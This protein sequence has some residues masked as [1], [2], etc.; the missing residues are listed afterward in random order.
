MPL[1]C[2][3]RAHN[4]AGRKLTGPPI[5]E[6]GSQ[7]TSARI[8]LRA[9]IDVLPA[10]LNF[11]VSEQDPESVSSRSGLSQRLGTRQPANHPRYND[12]D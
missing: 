3:D 7:S 1:A 4:Y 10:D 5:R 2:A 12:R 8:S 11:D 6:C 9:G